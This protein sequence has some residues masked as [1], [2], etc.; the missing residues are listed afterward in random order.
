MAGFDSGDWPGHV[1]AMSTGALVWSSPLAASVS[2]SL[3]VLKD[4]PLSPG[5]VV[6]PCP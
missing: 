6:C 3:F 4:A 5:R 1:A 2:V